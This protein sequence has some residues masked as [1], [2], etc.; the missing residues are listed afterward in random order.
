MEG[1]MQLALSIG[2]YAAGFHAL[3]WI[4]FALL[5]H[6][7]SFHSDLDESRGEKGY[8][9]ALVVSTAH[10][11]IMVVAPLAA[12]F[13]VPELLSSTDFFFNTQLSLLTCQ[14]FLGYTFQDLFLC[15]WFRSKWADMTATLMHHV[16]VLIAWWQLTAGGYAQGIALIA[17][18]CEISTLFVNARWILGKAGAK[19]GKVYIINGLIMTI[20]FFIFRVCIYDWQVVTLYHQREGLL[21]LPVFNIAC[22][23]F[24]YLAGV[25]LQ[26]FWMSKILRGVVKV[27]SSKNEYEALESK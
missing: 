10:A 21:S 12:I 3:Y 15:L 22:F 6:V 5:P 1:L 19:N 4:S 13:S 11:V 8:L 2:L 14:I 18:S 9:A 16:C 26:S 23:L 20:F 17:Q 25:L 24:C 7:V 27:F